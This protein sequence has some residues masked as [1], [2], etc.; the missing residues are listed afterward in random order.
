M[1]I[2]QFSCWV[3]VV[4]GTAYFVGSALIAS[5]FKQRGEFIRTLNKQIMKGYVDG[6]RP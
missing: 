3:L 1:T 2:F 4:G 6:T 5:Y